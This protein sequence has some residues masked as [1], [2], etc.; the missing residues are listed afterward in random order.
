MKK[1]FNI[2]EWQKKFII[3]ENTLGQLPSDKLMKMKEIN[4]LE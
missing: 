1:R 3:N 2:K 4:T